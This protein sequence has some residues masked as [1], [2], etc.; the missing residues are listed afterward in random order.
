MRTFEFTLKFTLPEE[1]SAESYINKLA[2]SGCDDALIG[3]GQQGRIALQFSREETTASEAILSAI[4]D[5]KRAIP[6]GVLIEATPDLVGVTD[7]AELFG[8]SRQNMRKLIL[9][10][11]STFP[12]PIHDGKSSIWHLA[13]VLKWFEQDNRRQIDPSLMEIANTV[14]QVN[15]AKESLDLDPNFQSKVACLI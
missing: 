12:S 9:T 2:E 1:K 7:I 8:F 11:Q 5:V 3:I 6:N 4:A 13:K 10:Y 15:L 14:M